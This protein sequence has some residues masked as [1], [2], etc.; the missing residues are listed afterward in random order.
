[1]CVIIAK[2]IN[3]SWK[4][5]KFRDRKYN[6]KYIIKDYPTSNVQ[7]TYLLDKKTKWL[8]GI[9]SNGITFVSAALDNH[10]DASITDKAKKQN[11]K[12][13]KLFKEYL[14]K[15]NQRNYEILKRTLRQSD[16]ESALNVLVES[17]FIGNTFITDG[18]KL[19]SIEIAIPQAKLLQYRQDDN[20]KDLDF[21][22]FKAKIMN[23]LSD[24]DF[25][26]SVNDASNDKLLVKTNHSIRI[27]GLGYRE[28]QRGYESSVER[29]NIVLSFMKSLSDTLSAEEIVYELSNL[30]LPKYNSN[31]E[32]RPLRIK[33]KIDMKKSEKEKLNITSYYTTDIFGFDPTKKTIYV[34]P[35]HSKIENYG[36]FIK[37]SSLNHIVILNR[38]IFKESW[39]S[40]I[41]LLIN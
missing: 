1:M 2:K 39:K 12:A 20:F 35:L 31:P 14:K 16:I 30:D 26:V 33:D 17:K 19:Y 10:A 38:N 37:K 23:N 8:E 32:Y 29:R 27:K 7:I 28:G 15:T 34:L 36:N 6:P 18:K 21:K 24:E 11:T 3:S 9:N 41:G 25:K 5:F 4:L 22:E 13:E 40:V